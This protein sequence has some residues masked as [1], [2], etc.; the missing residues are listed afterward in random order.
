MVS[1]REVPGRELSIP[2]GFIGFRWK[3]A[4]I[5]RIWDLVAQRPPSLCPRDLSKTG[6]HRC[7]PVGCPGP[8]PAW[9]LSLYRNPQRLTMAHPIRGYATAN[10]GGHEYGSP[11][12][13][14][15]FRDDYIP[16]GKVNATTKPFPVHPPIT[17]LNSKI[18]Y[19]K[20]IF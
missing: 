11:P 8:G 10:T 17:Y 15:Q 18:T 2:P 3:G 14:R 12:T 9:Q 7:A 6:R 5:R 16:R 1:L 19:L 20:V 13:G 4:E